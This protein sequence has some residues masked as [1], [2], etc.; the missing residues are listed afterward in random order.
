NISCSFCVG[1]EG[2]YGEMSER[3]MEQIVELLPT[4]MNFDVIGPGEPL[5]SVRFPALLAHIA[6][7]GY[8]SLSV[9]ITTNGTLVTPRWV[10][11]HAGVNWGNVRISLNAGSAAT[12][13]RMT[14]KK[15]MFDRVIA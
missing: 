6:D 5:M 1:P 10:A 2:A 14:G 8:P 15:Q 3:R 12:H 11:R 4:L 13:E 7:T 9:S